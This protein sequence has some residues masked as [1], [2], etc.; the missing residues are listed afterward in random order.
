MSAMQSHATSN[1]NSIAQ[2]ASVEALNGP[3][4]TVLAMTEEF[5]KR[6]LYMY[7]RVSKFPYVDVTMPQGAFYV[8]VDMTEAVSKKYK[9]EVLGTSSKLAEC[10]LNDCAV[11]VIPCVDYG[12]PN[13]IR[14]PY[15]ISMEQIEKGLDRIEKFLNELQ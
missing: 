10:L 13:H 9:G 14:L 3:Q 4:D 1:P 15:A 8:F 11:A 7:D 6:R 2:Y 5:N 12:F